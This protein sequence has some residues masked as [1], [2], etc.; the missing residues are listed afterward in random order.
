MRQTRAAAGPHVK[1][2]G[3]GPDGPRGGPV[4]AATQNQHD[5]VSDCWRARTDD[6]RDLER[7]QVEPQRSVL[8][9]ELV[10]VTTRIA[11]ASASSA[12]TPPIARRRSEDGHV[13]HIAAATH[14]RVD[15]PG[16]VYYRRKLA[17]GKTRMEAM[18]C[19]KR[20]ISDRLPTADH[21]RPA[22][23]RLA[24]TRSVARAREGTAGRSKSS[25]VDLPPHIDTSDQP[26]PGPATTTLHPD[27]RRPEEPPRKRSSSNHHL[28]TEG[29]PV[30]GG[31]RSAPPI[32][33]GRGLLWSP[34]DDI[35][36]GQPHRPGWV[37]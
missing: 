33:V 22:T 20:R 12:P 15:S 36:P 24:L 23:R 16:R 29:V 9:A 35:K 34:C 32:A 25:A 37:S 7:R 30:W 2:A 8:E 11:A 17:A 10:L 1:Y 19:L 28:T 21:R 26:L 13:L 5:E 6:E 31:F 3:G 27:P 18:R 14:M 4:T